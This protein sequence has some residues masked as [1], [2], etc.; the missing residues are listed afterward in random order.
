MCRLSLVLMVSDRPSRQFI[1]IVIF[2]DSF[3]TECSVN[4]L[5]SNIFSCLSAHTEIKHTLLEFG[6]APTQVVRTGHVQ[7]IM[8]TRG[9]EYKEVGWRKSKSDANSRSH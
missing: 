9:K 2:L 6:T 8:H 5:T 4:D 1:D 7:Q 3:S